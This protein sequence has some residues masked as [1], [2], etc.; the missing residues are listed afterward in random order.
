MEDRVRPE[1]LHVMD[2]ARPCGLGS[3]QVDVLGAHT[4]EVAAMAGG[5]LALEQ[6]H[7]RRA[8]EA[9]DVAGELEV[10]GENYAQV[11]HIV[12]RYQTSASPA[13]IQMLARSFCHYLKNTI[14]AGFDRSYYPRI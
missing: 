7:L 12:R 4:E 5:E 10:G 1:A 3:A 14:A 2:P 9:S 8:D 13:P 6:V 11:L